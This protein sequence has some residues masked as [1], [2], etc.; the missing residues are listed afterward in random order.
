V[1]VGVQQI[2][3]DA[4]RHEACV[5]FPQQREINVRAHDGG[6]LEASIELGESRATSASHFED[7][8]T[9]RQ[10]KQMNEHRDLNS[11]LQRVSG[12]NLG[13]RP[14]ARTFMPY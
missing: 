10:A 4:A 13:K 12:W 6:R 7:P 2:R 11:D 1:H 9:R 5:G 14:I 3:M 8:S